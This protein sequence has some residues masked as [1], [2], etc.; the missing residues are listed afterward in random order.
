MVFALLF[1][2]ARG[3]HACSCI[4]SPTVL[5]AYERAN[6]VVIVRVVSVEKSEKAAPEGQIADG[7]RYVAGVKS[8]RVLVE[9]AFKGRLKAGDEMTFAQ[10]GGA[11]CIWTFN[12]Q[13][14]G[15]KFLFYLNPLKNSAVWMAG[16]CGR[17]TSVE[18]AGD[19]LLYL[20]NL[21]K[22][23]GK[24]RLSGTIGFEG[25]GP[26]VGGRMIRIVGEK[27]SYE[28]KTDSKGVYEIY[29]LPA[30]RYMVEPE[31][32]A[33][34]KLDAYWLEYSPSVA[35]DENPGERQSSN[36]IPVIVEDRKHA[37]LDIRFE[38]DN[39]VRGK[40]LDAGGRPMR[41]VCIN[42]IP[43]R[44]GEKGAYHA[45]CTEEDG[46]F[47]ITELEPGNYI[48]VANDGGKVSSTEPFQTLYYPNVFEREKA[49][50]FTIGAGDKLEDFNIFIP[51]MQEV[52]TV[53]GVFLYSDGKPVI[54]ERVEFKAV[55][56]E[57]NVEGNAQTVTDEKGRFRIKILKG[58]Q[59]ELYGEMYTYEGEFENCP[60]LDAVIKKTGVRAPDIKT[61]VMKIR[62]DGDLYDV[63][64]KYP[65]PGCRKAK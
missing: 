10:G 36:K 54:E 35:G 4:A 30:G 62:A 9:R 23:R 2:A 47:V 19:D 25:D 53:E 55:E 45:D 60:K 64:L 15:Q 39:A 65:F 8:T 3:A 20:N 11:D 40:V 18:S 13:S 14:V 12:E 34:W 27:K 6:F 50:V 61:P 31:T 63:E 57:G 16:T 17:S 33:G 28:V 46:S 22:V 26:S 24:T 7:E 51:K 44:A 49:G 42:A 52:I 48:L 58:L 41:G 38:I 59:G 1:F 21:G 37:A 5:D 56:T 29:D 32:P 43:A